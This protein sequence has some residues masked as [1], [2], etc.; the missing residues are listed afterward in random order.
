MLNSTHQYDKKTILYFNNHSLIY[1]LYFNNR[2]ITEI[3][4]T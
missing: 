1:N 3:T 4:N 2:N